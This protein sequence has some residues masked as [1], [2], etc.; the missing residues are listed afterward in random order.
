ML[1]ILRISSARPSSISQAH[2]YIRKFAER[3]ALEA[4]NVV[5]I[6]VLEKKIVVKNLA[7]V[8][9]LVMVKNLV[10]VKNP[11]KKFGWGKESW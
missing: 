10:V 7:V 4:K 9:K 6:S 8:K 5:K 2:T 1:G 3:A 11:G